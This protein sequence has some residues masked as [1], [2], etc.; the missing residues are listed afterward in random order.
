L[1]YPTRWQDFEPVFGLYASQLS[2]LFYECAEKLY[3]DI[4]DSP[5][6][7]ARLSQVARKFVR[8]SITIWIFFLLPLLSLS[9]SVF[10]I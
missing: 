8:T 2:E 3:E 9:Y 1:A 10:K 4:D 5:I 6:F 7:S